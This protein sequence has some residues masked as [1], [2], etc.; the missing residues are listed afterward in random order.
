MS[1]ANA[2]RTLLTAAAR[3]ALA[4]ALPAGSEVR[5]HGFYRLKGI[6]TPLEILELG[7][8]GRV[9]FDPP[10][11][12]EKCWRVVRTGDLWVPAKSTRHNL[13]P[14]RDA[15]VGRTAELH[16]L[17][18]QLDAG[19][20]LVSIVGT[21]GTG[22]TR[23]AGHFARSRLDRWPDGAYFC[24]LSE[25]RSID[26]IVGVVAA[27][28]GVQ[29]D[30][31]APR[32]QLTQALAASGRCLL[33]LD[34]FEQIV[35]HAQQTV[36][37]WLDATVDAA[38]IVTSREPLRISG[39]NVFPLDPLP[40]AREGVELFALRARQRR[41]DFS[42]DEDNRALVEQIVRLL[43]GL[44]LAIELAA[45]RVPLL[46]V[47]G[48][49]ER[50]H[51]RFRL[52]TGGSRAAPRRQQTLREAIDWSHSLLGQEDMAVFRR[53]GA[54][55]GSFSLPAAQMTLADG[56]L[57]EWAVLDHLAVLVDKSLLVAD[58]S[59]PPRYRLLDS[60][61]AYALEKLREAGE[62]DE[63]LRRHAKSMRTIF[64][65]AFEQRWTSSYAE[66]HERWLPEFDNLRAAL[67]WAHG[68]GDNEL[69]IA[70]VGASYWLWFGAG[71]LVEGRRR[72]AQALAL[73]D[74]A[75]PAALEARLQIGWWSLSLPSTAEAPSR[76]I[77]RA[78]A[79]CRDVGDPLLLCEALLYWAQALGMRNRPDAAGEALREAESL[80]DP[81]WPAALRWQLHSA[82]SRMAYASGQLPEATVLAQKE[83]AI[84]REIGDHFFINI[85]LELLHFLA[86]AQG[87]FEQAAAR[88]E[89]IV[90]SMRKQ[91]FPGHIG[92]ALGHLSIAL[93]KLGRPNEA[94]AAAREAMEHL[95][96]QER[97]WAWLDDFAQLAY[98]RGR[99]SA[100]AMAL[101]RSEVTHI[102]H[103]T[104]RGDGVLTDH[105]EMLDSL[106]QK[107]GEEELR[108]LLACGATLSDE[109]AAR[110]A[111]GD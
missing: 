46:G 80:F 92:K 38:F 68:A 40:V 54:F 110:I 97:V 49:R 104:P 57:D 27:A 21:G 84:A 14:E 83:L 44:P 86:S 81:D 42:L 41:P 76:A 17:Q 56:E 67:D 7:R 65:R 3:L 26:D 77:E 20:R 102:E 85:S 34:N 53:V 8:R 66:R 51:E 29:L 45:A 69:E 111:L 43:D 31:S 58:A 11:D 15:F 79:L 60:T 6:E 108:R 12:S 100:A 47:T 24:D 90:A 63:T 10:P 70:L 101:G 75:T 35:A 2:G 37:A 78:V 13:P 103:G 9:P 95:V 71:H 61:R 39:E 62:T 106:R 1:L 96:Q 22:K 59:E 48:V 99:L 82:R 25:A 105:E 73:V 98:R 72:C 32:A 4:D 28:L 107:L 36:G 93:A 55:V 52:L 94:L 23:C 109:E 19:A 18:D 91:R 33:I 50:L 30:E 74:T 88:C 87:D 5:S 16:A 64:E 89:E